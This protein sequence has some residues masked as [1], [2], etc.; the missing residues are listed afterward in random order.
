MRATV[1]APQSVGI[2][3]TRQFFKDT[4]AQV[5]TVPGVLAAGATM[6]PPGHVDSV[7]AYLL[8]QLP[9]LPD[10]NRAPGAVLSIVA[11]GTFAALRIPLKKGRDFSN[12]DSVDRP[13]V[14]IVNESLVRKSFPK[15]DPTGRTIFCPFDS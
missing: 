8:D 3:R 4:L 15:Q 6:A 2:A 1:P 11:P 10:W 5:A 7:G 9:V 12:S 13:F 14:A